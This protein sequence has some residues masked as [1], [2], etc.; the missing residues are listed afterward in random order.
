MRDVMF[1][2]RNAP[3]A[4]KVGE[5]PNG[6]A[7][8]GLDFLLDHDLNPKFCEVVEILDDSMAPEFPAGAVG[9]VDL[10][11][12]E[13]VDGRICAVGVPDLTVRRMTKIRG[14][15]TLE[16]DNPAFGALI[17]ADHFQVQG[18]VVWTSHMVGVTALV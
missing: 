17:R 11:R 4:H 16:A 13:W 1:S 14:G 3:A 10:R 18:Q 15:W 6:C 9:L 5:A 2:Q 7:F 12:R 8:F